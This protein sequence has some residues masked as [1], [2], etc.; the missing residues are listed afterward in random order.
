V[1]AA[2]VECCAKAGTETANKAIQETN[3][4][5][6]DDIGDFFSFRLIAG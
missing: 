6:E 3:V 2:S 1:L 5:L 4:F